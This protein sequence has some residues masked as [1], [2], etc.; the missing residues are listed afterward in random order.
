MQCICQTITTGQLTE[1]TII[2][3]NVKK[4]QLCSEENCCKEPERICVLC[5]K[6]YC[7]K[8]SKVIINYIIRKIQ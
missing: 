4:I 1:C 2:P 5:E 7:N 6:H 3:Q 8:C